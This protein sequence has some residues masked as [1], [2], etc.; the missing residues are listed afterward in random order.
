MVDNKY[1]AKLF[2]LIFLLLIS[3]SNPFPHT[4]S[5]EELPPLLKKLYQTD[6]LRNVSCL[7]KKV[8]SPTMN[9]TIIGKCFLGSDT[10]HPIDTGAVKM[11][12]VSTSAQNS[13][14]YTWNDWS[15][16]S[17]PSGTISQGGKFLGKINSIQPGSY[18]ILLM[19]SDYAMQWWDG[20]NVTEQPTAVYLTSDTIS[21]E[22]HFIPSCTL[23]CK[24][25]D[26]VTDSALCPQIGI[27]DMSGFF[28]LPIV[29]CGLSYTTNGVHVLTH[30][31]VGEYYLTVYQG[32][33][34][35]ENYLYPNAKY[36]AAAT[37]LSFSTPG[38]RTDT[39]I[40]RL[41]KLPVKN[42]VWDSI[43]VT[44]T[45]TSQNGISA[46][47]LYAKRRQNT[48]F[49]SGEVTEQLRV[50]PDQKFFLGQ[51]RGANF[52]GSTFWL[53]GTFFRS[54]ADT[55]FV[56]QSQNHSFVF[57]KPSSKYIMQSSFPD[58]TDKRFQF[59][60]IF[61][62][63]G[64]TKSLGAQ[65]NNDTTTEFSMPA[66]SGTYSFNAIPA[67]VGYFQAEGWGAVGIDS[68][69]IGYNPH[70]NMQDQTIFFPKMQTTLNTH[71]I[72]G[73]AQCNSDPLFACFDSLGRVVSLTYINGNS[74]FKD[75]GGAKANFFDFQFTEDLPVTLPFFIN[76]LPP[77]RFAIAKI[78]WPDSIYGPVN[79]SW[80]GGPSFSMQYID[81]DDATLLS[82]PANISW[83]R[84]DSS[85]SVATLSSWSNV[86]PK[87][88]QSSQGLQRDVLRFNRLSNGMIAMRLSPGGISTIVRIYSVEGRRLGSFSLEKGTEVF[89]DRRFFNKPVI[90]EYNNKANFA[91]KIFL[92]K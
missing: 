18:Y 89:L 36:P 2:L 25:V 13:K 38:S 31:P 19:P 16:L 57:P 59:V 47:V 9:V 32:I 21:C 27:T 45:D 68:V 3:P 35:Y 37:K 46:E 29:D 66:D 48:L 56:N 71:S 85:T 55:M 17:V 77:G 24:T 5:M 51:R 69:F 50:E 82:L 39:L 87:S 60:P 41:S 12:P 34:D 75:L 15:I 90:V 7:K 86:M 79:V 30:I 76:C 63:R 4:P 28:V 74:Y 78:E 11:L 54:K 88:S 43:I 81:V 80:Y 58:F 22:F 62:N 10:L 26:A 52:T 8:S 40:W 91:K 65:V 61:T 20:K 72:S 49:S 73:T 64:S 83:I 1:L 67:T 6:S 44:S 70:Y 33:L 42:I 92:L 53:P 84:I 14:I 23:I